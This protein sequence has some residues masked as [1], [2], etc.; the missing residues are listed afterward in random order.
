[1][2]KV[3]GVYETREEAVDAAKTL[4]Y[5]GFEP[6]A[7]TIYN[8]DDLSNNHIH[9][10]MDHRFEIT[11]LAIG[12][13]LGGVLGIMSGA[14]LFHIP[15]FSFIYDHGVIRG[16]LSGAIFGLL[17]SAVVAT[18]S[19]LIMYFQTVKR[20]EENLNEGRY[21]VFYE[22]HRKQDIHRAHETL[23]TP[24]LRIELSAH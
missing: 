19:T 14:G 5:A 23:H 6:E 4:H 1:M 20:N 15:G 16:A 10:K 3:V 24:D 22:G 9:V 12:I 7:I 8:R 18:I 11:E 21:L 17:I 13:G 2:N